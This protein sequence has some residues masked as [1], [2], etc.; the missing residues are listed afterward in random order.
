[1]RYFCWKLHSAKTSGKWHEADNPAQ[2]AEKHADHVNDGAPIHKVNHYLVQDSD[3]A[4]LA[5]DVSSKFRYKAEQQSFSP[6]YLDI[7]ERALMP[8]DDSNNG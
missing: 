7:N 4:I 3:G 8:F 6:D 5:F 2:A 1:M